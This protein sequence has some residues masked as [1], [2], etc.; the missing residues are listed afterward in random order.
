MGQPG[1]LRAP[2][3]GFLDPGAGRQ[4][5]RSSENDPSAPYRAVRLDTGFLAAA[6]A[7]HS[8][9]R[10]GEMRARTGGRGA[11]RMFLFVLL[12]WG[13]GVCGYM[14]DRNLLFDQGVRTPGENTQIV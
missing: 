11:S 12:P 5:E 2:V 6:A 14:T 10:Q 4:R 13:A 3:F 8:P 1:V 9:L 7:G